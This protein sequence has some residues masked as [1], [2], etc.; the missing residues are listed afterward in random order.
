MCATSGLEDF[1]A[2]DGSCYLFVDEAKTFDDAE[3]S[4][5]ERGAHLASILNAGSEYL[6][7]TAIKSTEAWIGLSNK[8]VMALI[9]TS[10]NLILATLRLLIESS[11]IFR[12][13]VFRADGI[14]SLPY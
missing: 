13:M 4:C 8:K 5:R 2:F 3:A 10:L 9:S 1:L 14:E 12:I 11:P 6:A 7:I